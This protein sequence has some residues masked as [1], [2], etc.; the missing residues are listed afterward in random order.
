MGDGG[1]RVWMRANDATCYGVLCRE[2]TGDGIGA[3]DLPKQM[4]LESRTAALHFAVASAARRWNNCCALFADSTL[5]AVG[6]LLPRCLQGVT[7]CAPQLPPCVFQ[8]AVA[9]CVSKKI[10][11]RSPQLTCKFCLAAFSDFLDIVVQDWVRP[12]LVLWFANLQSMFH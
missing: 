10:C 9:I 8:K 2:V 5:I 4:L 12:S 11:R 7:R 3:L 6:C 1:K